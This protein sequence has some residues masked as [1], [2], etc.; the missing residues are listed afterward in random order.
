MS[1]KEIVKGLVGKLPNGEKLLSDISKAKFDK[2]VEKR[3]ALI[4]E[5]GSAIIGEVE[6]ALSSSGLEYFATCGTLLGLIRENRLLK[7]DYD[8]DYAILVNDED[9]WNKLE[10]AIK[11][12]GYSKVHFFTLDGKITEQTYRSPSGIDVDFF[13]HF[14]EGKELCFY[15]Y[16]K[17]EGEDYPTPSHWTTYMFHTGVYD[18]VKK[19]DTQL[20]TVTVPQN[21]E[22]YLAYNYNDDW[23]IPDPNYVAYTGKGCSMLKGKY[24]IYGEI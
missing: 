23:R 17:I 10:T 15:A 18:G 13:G 8:L 9:S 2:N 6:E 22:E 11:G 1:A 16:D 24:G 21:A 4:N 5:K 19:I 3:I 14:F 7:N 20:G 12:K